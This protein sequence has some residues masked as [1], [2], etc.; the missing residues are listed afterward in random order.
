MSPAAG[1]RRLSSS[2]RAPRRRFP[3]D[4]DVIAAIGLW[5]AAASLA[6]LVWVLLSTTG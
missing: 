4:T 6:A 3:T 2:R 1:P 5:L